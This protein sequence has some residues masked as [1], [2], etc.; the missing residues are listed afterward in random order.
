M[1]RI[2]YDI[3]KN[4]N[5]L[6][7]LD[8]S[9][10]Q[11]YTLNEYEYS[12]LDELGLNSDNFQIVL[13]GNPLVCNCNN[14]DFLSWIS[15]TAVVYKKDELVCSTAEGR[16]TKIFDFLESFDQFKD[17]CVSQSWLIISVTLTVICFVLIILAREAWR[18]SV[19]LRIM[20][21]HPEESSKYTNSIY[22]S[23]CSK[24]SSWVKNTLAPWLDEKQI[25]FCCDDKT[26]IP[27]RDIADNIMD[28]IGS[29]RQTLFV[30]SYAFLER[31]WTTFTMKLTYEYSFRVGRE[32]MNIFILLDDIKKSEFPK[33]IR[34]YW[35]SIHPLR[36]P[37]E[38]NI[39]LER[40]DCARNKFWDGLSR[41]IPRRKSDLK[42]PHVTETIL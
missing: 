26:F 40:T 30:I 11:I 3:L 1:D 25:D 10:N 37:K 42:S 22:I 2:P 4:L 23:Y 24:D 31:E 32:N 19:W 14:L 20:C 15:T 21:R 29:S 13:F 28:A 35:K 7:W 5:E 36:W 17:H 12:L 34:H 16:R 18:R 41:R 27:G 38:C 9:N 8:M 6:E 33:L 39:N